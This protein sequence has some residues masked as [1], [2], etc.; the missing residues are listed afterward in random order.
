M[1]S[2]P[3]LWPYLSSLVF[4]SVT[5]FSTS[6]PPSQQPPQP[7]TVE[8]PTSSSHHPWVPDLQLSSLRSFTLHGPL[9]IASPLQILLRL[10]LWRYHWD[11]LTPIYTLVEASTPSKTT[12]APT[13]RSRFC[14]VDHASHAPS[15]RHCTSRFSLMC[16]HVPQFQ[17]KRRSHAFTRSHALPRPS[18]TLADVIAD[19][20]PRCAVADITCLRQPLTSSFDS[21]GLT[22]DFLGLI[23]DFDQ[24]INCWLFSR[25]DFCS[26]G[27]LPSFSCRFHFCSLFLHIVSLYG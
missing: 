23:V 24:A 20:S 7:F 8:P 1:V 19:I 15:T 17:V 16:S 10:R 26:L 18:T 5:S 14:Y 4:I 13:R 9:P 3:L 12:R 21:G 11:R 6:L 25:V 2:E 22:V 27:S